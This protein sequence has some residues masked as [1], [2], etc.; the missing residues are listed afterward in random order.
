[1]GVLA[2]TRL[3]K[4]GNFDR[5]RMDQR[6]SLSWFSVRLNIPSALLV[7]ACAEA[8]DARDGRLFL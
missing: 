3:P 5:V 8:S 4:K 1:M 7:D 2:S 6:D